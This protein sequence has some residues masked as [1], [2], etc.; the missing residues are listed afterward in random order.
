MPIRRFGSSYGGEATDVA[1]HL[2]LGHEFRASEHAAMTFRKTTPELAKQLGWVSLE[3]NHFNEPGQWVSASG[4]NA[5]G[6]THAWYNSAPYELEPG[7]ALVIRGR[8]PDCRFANV[9]L[10]NSFMQS[11]DYANRQVSLNRKQINYEDDGS[12]RLVIAHEDPGVPNWLD[13]EGRRSGQV[14]WRYVFPTSTPERPTTEVVKVAS[15]RA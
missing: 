11:F 4:D 2:T 14:Y 10:W 7:E 1:A 6:N 13:T 3:A 12:F 8:F 5:Y 9:V 15:L